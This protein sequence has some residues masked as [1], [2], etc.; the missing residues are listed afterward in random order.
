MP[1]AAIWFDLDDT[2]Y[3]HTYS[4]ARGLDAICER[5]PAFRV[6]PS[7]ELAVLYNQALNAVHTDYLRGDIDFPE[8]RRRKLK[9]FGNAIQLPDEMIPTIENFHRIYDVEYLANRRATPGSVEIL[10]QLRDSSIDMAILTNGKQE[11][12][13][14]KLRI[15]G[16][17]W[18]SPCLL[19][20]ER[21][22]VTKPDPRIYEWALSQ[23]G[24]SSE[25]VLMIGDSL[26]NDVRAPLKCGLRAALYDPSAQHDFASTEY[27][28][29]PIVKEWNS[30]LSL[31]RGFEAVSN[32]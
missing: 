13:E 27:G 26:E 12:Q 2:L 8:M 9:R 15:I 22:G 17:E 16:L 32:A 30:L 19:T 10:E 7:D 6:A 29:V 20:S 25:N 14:E 3:D 5:Y 18:M 24:Q 4:V 1:P 21:A 28:N 31:L 11:M 23:T